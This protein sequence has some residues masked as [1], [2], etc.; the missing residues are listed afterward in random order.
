MK[1]S[2]VTNICAS[3][4]VVLLYLSVLAQS[5]RRQIQFVTALC[6]RKINVINAQKMQFIFISVHLYEIEES[7][8]FL[9]CRDF[10]IL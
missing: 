8:T 10:V 3:G 6:K 4:V 2:S 7:Q 1:D 5:Q 9:C